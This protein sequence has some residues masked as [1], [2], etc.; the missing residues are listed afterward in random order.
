MTRKRQ[1]RWLLV[2]AHDRGVAGRLHR[3]LVSRGAVAGLWAEPRGALRSTLAYWG[4]T[5]RVN[6]ASAL[7]RAWPVMAAEM[8]YR[9][10]VS[11]E[12]G[13]R[14]GRPAEGA[15]WTD[16]SVKAPWGGAAAVCPWRD[17]SPSCESRSRGA[18][19]AWR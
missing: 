3:E 8:P 4:W 10:R 6:W 9:G 16:G 18:P 15:V 5:V 11:K 17:G 13:P 14:D 12:P 1:A 2:L 7:V 19:P